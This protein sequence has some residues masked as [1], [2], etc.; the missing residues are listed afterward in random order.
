MGDKQNGPFQL[1]FNGSLKVD[2]QGSRVTS[3]GDLI[4]VRELD[5]R[6]GF[7]E[8]IGRRLVDRRQGKNPQFPLADPLR[9][10][11][12]SRLAG[13]EYVND[14]E[15]LSQDPTFGLIGSEKIWDRSCGPARCIAP[16][17]GKNCG[18]R[19][20]ANDSLERSIAEL[21]ARPVGRPSQKP[22]VWYKGSLYRAVVRFYNRRGT[23]R[24]VRNPL[25]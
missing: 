11:V 9:Q 7:G 5:E 8:L 22:V 25:K 13:Y 2:F 18:C 19:I 17:V 23:E 20:P 12:Y 21:L 16:T 14:A 15:R 3:D 24:S 6:L 4:L 1:S 10:S